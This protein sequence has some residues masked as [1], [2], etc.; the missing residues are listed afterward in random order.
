MLI[1]MFSLSLDFPLLFGPRSLAGSTEV[2]ADV[3]ISELGET[4]GEGEVK[5]DN[6][7]QQQREDE[8]VQST[9]GSEGRKVLSGRGY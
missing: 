8:E 2:P 3:D 1:L 9:Q 6:E 4:N 7:T 5:E